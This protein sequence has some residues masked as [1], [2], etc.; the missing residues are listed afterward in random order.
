M[1]IG[2]IL[3]WE[4]T[5]ELV[6]IPILIG[7]VILTRWMRGRPVYME[8]DWLFLTAHPREKAVSLHRWQRFA[9]GWLSVVLIGLKVM[10]SCLLASQHLLA[11]FFSR[12][13][14]FGVLRRN[15]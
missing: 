10:F 8:R 9:M 15:G 12:Y 4:A 1:N 2:E 7:L 11:A 5:N 13:L 6:L 3:I 14:F